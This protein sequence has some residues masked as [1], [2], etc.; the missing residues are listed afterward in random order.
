MSEN[1]FIKTIKTLFIDLIGEILYFPIWW[2]TRGLKGVFVY[3][4]RSVKKLAYSLSLKVMITHLLSPMF[5]QYDRAG[6]AISFF[7]R[8]ILLISRFVVFVI[9]TVLYICLL[10]FWVLLP[11]VVIM[12]LV[13]NLRVLWLA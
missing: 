11:L 2:Y 7:M 1:I 4:W 10:A 6:R 13:N 12:Q 3:I 9:G 5:G 8:F